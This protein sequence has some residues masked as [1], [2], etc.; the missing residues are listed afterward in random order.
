MIYYMTVLVPIYIYHQSTY[1]FLQWKWKKERRFIDVLVPVI[2]SVYYIHLMIQGLL[3]KKVIT[4]MMMMMVISNRSIP[5]RQ[6]PN[7]SNGITWW[8]FRSEVDT[9]QNDDDFDPEIDI[10]IRNKLIMIPVR[11]TTQKI[12]DNDISYSPSDNNLPFLVSIP[13][14]TAKIEEKE[15]QSKWQ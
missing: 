6:L 14:I 1:C 15:L 5:I 2:S 7:D 3:W 9:K 12:P 10:S 11:D 13:A 8:W 4:L